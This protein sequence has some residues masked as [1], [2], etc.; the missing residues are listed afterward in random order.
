[1]TS[2]WIRK[3]EFPLNYAR[4]IVDVLHAMSV[5]GTIRVVGTSSLRAVQYSADVDAQ[6]DVPSLSDKQFKGVIRRLQKLKGVRIGDIKCG[7]DESKRVI[8]ADAHIHDCHV[9]GYDESMP[10]IQFLE[11]KASHKEHILRWT[12]QQV[13]KGRDGSMTLKEAL[14]TPGTIKVDTLVFSDGRFIEVSCVYKTSYTY[15]GSMSQEL[16]ESVL[17]NLY[18]GNLFK[19]Y[20][21]IFSVARLEQDLPTIQALI[22]VFNGDLGNLYTILSDIQ[23]LQDSSGLPKTLLAE[24]IEG[25]RTRLASIWTLPSLLK[26]EPSL[27]KDI[28]RLSVSP[29]RSSRLLTTLEERL[30]RILQDAT[31]SAMEAIGLYPIPHKYLP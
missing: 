12:P 15:E 28:A 9:V 24:E 18:D 26:Q 7:S 21:R 27:D 22:E 2:P 23:V 31:P 11:A 17:A 29:L 4:P 13:L 6:E 1:M 16:K 25:F 8:P 10:P 5:N 3:K 30:S 20:R 19:A 14:K